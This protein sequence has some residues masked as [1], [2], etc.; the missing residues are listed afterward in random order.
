M[1]SRVALMSLSGFLIV[2]MANAAGE[3][4]T[5]K[6]SDI[7]NQIRQAREQHND[8]RVQGL[9]TAL[10][11]TRANCSEAG[12]QA[13]LEQRRADANA[14]VAEAQRDV[15]KAQRTLDQAKS[16]GRSAKKIADRQQKLDKA[17]R[18]LSERKAELKALGSM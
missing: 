15:S 12:E 11:Q 2:G 8:N 5:A 16:E 9:E 3:V 17:Q 18:K 13:K 7:E 10:Q 4:C 6:I 1:K 14:E